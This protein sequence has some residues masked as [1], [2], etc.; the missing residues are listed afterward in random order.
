M[1]R[2]K[3]LLWWLFVVL[4]VCGGLADCYIHDAVIGSGCLFLSALYLGFEIGYWYRNE[5]QYRT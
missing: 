1:A 5:E 3:N 4:F 2:L